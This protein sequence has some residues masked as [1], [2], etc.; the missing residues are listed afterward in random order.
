[1]FFYLNEITKHINKR[2]QK[3]NNVL[4]LV[5]FVLH[6]GIIFQT[7]LKVG[8]MFCH[9][10]FVKKDTLT[11]FVLEFC[12]LL[13]LNVILQVAPEPLSLNSVSMYQPISRIHKS[14]PVVNYFVRIIHRCA[15]TV[16]QNIRTPGIAYDDQSLPYV[17]CYPWF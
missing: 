8:G 9:C 17:F 12:N 13:T 14:Y 11:N 2:K 4:L 15:N 16:L 5:E 1:M 7:Q 3:Q 6:V 10:T